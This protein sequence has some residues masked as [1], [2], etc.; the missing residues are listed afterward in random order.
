MDKKTKN[1][2]TWNEGTRRAQTPGTV[3]GTVQGTDQGLIQGLGLNK[4]NY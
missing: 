3:Q 2:G 1:D 4:N